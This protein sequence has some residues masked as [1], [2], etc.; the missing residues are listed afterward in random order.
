MVCGIRKAVSF[1]RELHHSG[2]RKGVNTVTETELPNCLQTK[3]AKLHD[4][5][6]KIGYI[7]G[8]RARL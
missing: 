4:S 5:T 7:Y 2:E 8:D 3:Q 6:E 1:C